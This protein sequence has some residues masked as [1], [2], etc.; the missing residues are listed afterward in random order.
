MISD[1][2]VVIH[3]NSVSGTFGYE[4]SWSGTLSPNSKTIDVTHI[5]FENTKNPTGLACSYAGKEYTGTAFLMGA[6]A[7]YAK[8]VFVIDFDDGGSSMPTKTNLYHFIR[9]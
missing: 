9:Q 3:G 4:C 8:G 1:Y 7:A 5:T 2:A 6:S